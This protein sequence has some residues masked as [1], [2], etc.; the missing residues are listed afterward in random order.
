LH[1]PTGT[2]QVPPAQL[3]EQHSVFV[4]QDWWY[5]LH[6]A[7]LIPATQTPRTQH[8]PTQE[9][10]VQVHA[11]AVHFCPATQADPVPHLHTPAVHESERLGSQ[12]THPRP[13]VPHLAIVG[14]VTHVL[15][16]QQPVGQLAEQFAQAWLVQGSPTAQAAQAA[17]PVPHAVGVVPS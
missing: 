10:G 14:G 1:A 4:V 2:P 13:P 15:P 12:A 11:P 16:S 7:Q 17:P 8:P 3:F 9:V 5:D 6:V